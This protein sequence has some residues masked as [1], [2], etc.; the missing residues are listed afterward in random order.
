MFNSEILTDDNNLQETVIADAVAE[1]RD[2]VSEGVVTLEEMEDRAVSEKR[3]SRNVAITF[4]KED[5]ENKVR[6][7]SRTFTNIKDTAE[8]EDIHAAAEALSKLYDYD[9][10][11]VKIITTNLLEDD[12][13]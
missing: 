8:K 12:L 6:K 9:D 1:E 3:V 11:D 10:Y 13:D 4:R 5:H 7:F 2:M